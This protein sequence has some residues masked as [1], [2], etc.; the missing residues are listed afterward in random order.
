MTHII[1]TLFPVFFVVGLGYVLSRKNF[2]TRDFLD[3]LNKFVYYVSFPALILD[4]IIRAEMIPAGTLGLLVVYIVATGVLI[5]AGLLTARML[6]LKRWQYGTFLQI[7]TRGNIGFIGIPIL[8]YGLRDFG[9]SEA[10]I[11]MTQ[12]IILFAPI[13]IFHNITSVILLVGS[14]DSAL[15]KN[16]TGA[17][18]NIATN[19]LIIAA[20]IGLTFFFL[21]INLPVPVIDVF[22]YLGRTA[23]PLALVCVGGGMAYV[24][25]QG[26]Y[27]SALV[28]SALKVFIL[29]LMTYLISRPFGFSD[30]SILILMIYAAVPSA[31]AGYVMAKQLHGDEAMASGGVFYSTILSVISLSI[32][33]WLF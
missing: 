16:L 7:T 14:H 25:M 19:P 13:M 24:T 23:G 31:V 18:R 5:L 4:R 6:G 27:R 29:P 9:E 11:I 20:L 30:S 28:A 2:L 21:P 12:G 15:Q 33:V 22:S 3:V 1:S 10:S 32:V 8:V 26:R 17:L